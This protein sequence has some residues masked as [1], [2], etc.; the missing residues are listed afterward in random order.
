MRNIEIVLLG[1]DG[2]IQ[3]AYKNLHDFGIVELSI[4]EFSEKPCVILRFSCVTPMELF[5]IVIKNLCDFD[6]FEPSM[7][8]FSEKPFVILRFFCVT[9]MELSKSI[10][11]H[12][13]C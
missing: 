10:Q 7:F 13:I 11:K 8:E 6:I 4:F 1:T 9:P 12:M 5:K 2:V 3:K